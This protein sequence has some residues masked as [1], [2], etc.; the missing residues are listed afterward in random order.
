[1]I[2]ME[3]G[4][5]SIR[6]SSTVRRPRSLANAGEWMHLVTSYGNLVTTS[7]HSAYGHDPKPTRSDEEVNL[8]KAKCPLERDHGTDTSTPTINQ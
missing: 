5:G 8:Y 3:N 4:F 2:C 1:M 6:L 7:A